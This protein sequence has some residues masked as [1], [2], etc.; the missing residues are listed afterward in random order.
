MAIATSVTSGPRPFFYKVKKLVCGAVDLTALAKEHG[1][2]LYVYSAEQIRY[3]LELFE[4]AF[5]GRAH[6]IC[7][8]VK[9]N[10]SL[11]ILKLLADAGAGFDIVSGGELERVRRA[12]K[13]ALKR[14]VF[15]GVG[16]QVWEI[17][18][19]LKAGILLFNVESEAEL[20]LLAERAKL[21]GVKARFALR[22]NPDVFAETHPYISTGLRDH[23]FGIAIG[24]ARRIY[25]AAKKMGSL[26]AAGV[27]VH[28]GSQIRQVEPF[29]AALGRV[30]GLVKELREDGHSIR[31]VDAG[32]GLGIDYGMDASAVFDPAGQVE[33]YAAALLAV[34]GD[35]GAH[36]LLE[37]GRFLVAQAGALVSRI[38]FVK[39]NGTKT[40]VVTDA[41]MNDL[42]RPALYQAH[43]EIVP[44]K[45]PSGASEAV[46]IVGPVC[47]SGDFFARDRVMPKVKVGD[48]V[49]VLD[50]GAY[51]MSLA[52]NYNTRGRPAEVLV[53]G[54]RCDVIRRRETVKDMLALER[55]PG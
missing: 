37:P 43:H 26:D 14:V 38:L 19:A 39:K 31:Y 20:S 17:D 9:A 29:G 10:S 41:G 6:T 23:K 2:P 35:E 33:R 36:L 22:V 25:R 54:D 18:A 3:R 16:K 34:M 50:A 13:A 49:A 45:Q 28:I 5:S 48:L 1:T 55:M 12:S 53:D 40:F 27:S 11:A 44:V 46:D 7:Y 32:G 51:G 52:S 47:E 4:G 30:L 8:A 15:S 21:A 42:I 24:E